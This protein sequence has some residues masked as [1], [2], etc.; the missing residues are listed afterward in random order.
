MKRVQTCPGWSFDGW[1]K[2][3]KRSGLVPFDLHI[4]DLDFLVYAF[5]KP[6]KVTNFRSKRPE[7]DYMN[8][9][10][11]FDGFFVSA[12]ASWFAASYPFAMGFRFQFE[13]AIVELENGKLIIFEEGGKKIDLSG[14]AEGETGD[15]SLP[16]SD[17]YANE[18]RY[19]A[20]CV[21]NDTWPE[22]VKQEELETVIDILN[23][24]R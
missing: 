11:E 15:I 6:E 8:A 23:A 1:M 16:Q 5:G 14:T 13:R 7:Q 3:E 9:I 4:H 21:L 22:K 10:Y 2:D 24:A 12:E 18:I 17:A 19:F 20:D